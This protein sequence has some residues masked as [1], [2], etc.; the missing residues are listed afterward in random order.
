MPVKSDASAVWWASGVA[1]P[2]GIGLQ[3]LRCCVRVR[4]CV[5]CNAS[6]ESVQSILLVIVGNKRDRT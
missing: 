6:E 1:I 4:A 2:L 5:R 3:C